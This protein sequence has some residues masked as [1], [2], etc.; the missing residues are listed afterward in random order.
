MSRTATALTVFGV[1][2]GIFLAAVESTVVGTAMPTIIG[3]LG[4][5]SLYGWVFSAYLLASTTTVPLYGK[6]ADTFGRKPV[7]LF[8]AGLFLTGS[9]LCGLA[10]SMGQ[11]IAFRALQGLGAGAI[12]PIT[13]TIV[14]DLFSVEQ[15][16][17]MQGLFSGVWG[18]ASVTGPALGGFITDH[19]D[20]RWVFY[21]N[22]P[23]GLLSMGLLIVFFRERVERVRRPV[24]YVGTATLTA[25]VVL[26]LL[27]L[28]QGGEAWPWRSVQTFALV[29]SALMLFGVFLWNERRAPDPML[30][31]SLFRH[32]LIAVAGLASF[33]S[34]GVMFGVT[35]FVP[36]F[37]QGV[38]GGSATNAGMALA[39]LS[40]GWP[41]A[42]VVAG[43]M[44]LRVG[45]RAMGLLGG[46]LL[47]AGAAVLLAV[48]QDSSQALV[49]AAMLSIGAGMGFSSTSFLIAVQNAVAW[50]QRGVATASIQFFRTIGGS[51][52]VAAMGAMLNAQWRAH[53]AGVDAGGADV[54]EA[55]V[56]LDTAA[57][58][59]L[60]A[61]ALAALQG[62]LATSLHAVYLLVFA[63]AAAS[64]AAVLLFPSGSVAD[65]AHQPE[66][67]PGP[68]A[69]AEPLPEGAAPAG[70]PDRR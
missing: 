32:R 12:L 68:P 14:G 45:Y 24:D 10:G 51:I 52:A 4:G 58:G 16:A 67:P 47:V 70:D 50:S 13:L 56:L 39:P 64:M 31:P 30:P 6:L 7:F 19:L 54:S 44:I 42:S 27:A 22:V 38:L 17:R 37:V 59:A 28:L 15:R 26:F 53:G 66:A 49:M 23:F 69:P 35:T 29:G 33:V 43:R 61:E 2:L 63:A 9:M 25:A 36:P 46:V 40:I 62:A 5:V 34:G 18:V 57:R 3:K 11:L 21:V 55:N 20:W 48:G 8:G 65:L 1:M 60:P 41:V